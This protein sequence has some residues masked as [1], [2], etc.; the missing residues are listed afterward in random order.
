[1]RG[2]SDCIVP[3]QGEVLLHTQMPVWYMNDLLR[4][5]SWVRGRT[6]WNRST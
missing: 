3:A 6:N 2:I 1:V 4:M 5:R